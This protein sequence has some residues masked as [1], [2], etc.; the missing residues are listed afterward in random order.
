MTLR[1]EVSDRCPVWDREM[2]ERTEDSS[3]KSGGSSSL[4]TFPLSGHP[5][6]G[7]RVALAVA[8]KLGVFLL[9]S[10][11]S[12]AAMSQESMWVKGHFPP[13]PHMLCSRPSCKYSDPGVSCSIP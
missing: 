12:P 7:T 5:Y 8:H 3:R 6:P 10:S 9:S 2:P 13:N 1:H 11:H 4:T